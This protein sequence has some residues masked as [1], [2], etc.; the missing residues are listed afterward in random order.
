[1]EIKT[2]YEDDKTIV[3]AVFSREGLLFT[4]TYYIDETD[5]RPHFVRV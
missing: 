1:M 2:I 5:S 4:V 3:E